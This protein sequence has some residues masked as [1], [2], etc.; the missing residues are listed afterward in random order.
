MKSG[1]WAS[2]SPAIG[3]VP[4]KPRERKT[5]LVVEDNPGLAEACRLFLERA[6]F[7]AIVAATGREGLAR[8]AEDQPDLVLLDLSLPDLRGEDVADVL[9]NSFPELPA[10]AFSADVQAS[11][12]VHSSNGAFRGLVTKPAAGEV[13]LRAIRQALSETVER[14]LPRSYRRRIECGSS[15]PDLDRMNVPVRRAG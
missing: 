15:G 10:V 1:T 3:E 6:G 2:A 8:A 7:R 14:P 4:V 13:I 12:R 11:E 9:R 5:I